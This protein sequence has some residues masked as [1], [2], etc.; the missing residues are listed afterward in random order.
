MA[1]F[2]LWTPMHTCIL[3]IPKSFSQSPDDRVTSPCHVLIPPDPPSQLRSWSQPPGGLTDATTLV[4]TWHSLC[5]KIL[6]PWGAS[7]EPH[8]SPGYIKKHLP[9]G[10]SWDF[11]KGKRSW[12]WGKWA[13]SWSCPHCSLVSRS[14]AGQLSQDWEGQPR[15][16]VPWSLAG[17]LQEF[18]G[19]S[20]VN[21]GQKVKNRGQESSSHQDPR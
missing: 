2:C 16:W 12:W 14:R 4:Y 5:A 6:G 15:S 20:L 21:G 18:P 19:V 3:W 7:E 13:H 1:S 9:K 8:C 17:K 10:W 11:P